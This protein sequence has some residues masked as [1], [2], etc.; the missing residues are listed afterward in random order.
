MILLLLPLAFGGRKRCGRRG[1][2]VEVAFSRIGSLFVG[3]LV[4]GPSGVVSGN[5]NG[6]GDYGCRCACVG[7][8]TTSF[9]LDEK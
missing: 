4:G 6:G 1:E 9:D 7:N 5:C 2:L 3:W 8:E